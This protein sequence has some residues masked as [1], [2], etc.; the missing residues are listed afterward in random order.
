M[1]FLTRILSNLSLDG[2]KPSVIEVHG[3]SLVPVSRA[4]IL[5]FTLRARRNI[6]AA[7]VKAGDRVALLAPNSAKWA[8]CDLAI[9]SEGAIVVPLYSRQ[10]PHEL[11]VMLNDCKP[12]LLIAADETL[13]Q[14]ILDAW[15]TPCQTICFDPLFAGEASE[16]PTF[17]HAPKDPVTIIYTSGTSGVPKGVILNCAN[18]DYMLPTTYRAIQDITGERG[19]DDKVFHFLPFCFA[20]S[21]MMLWTQLYRPN[22][23]TASTDLTN[24][25]QEM[26]TAD[27]NYYLNVPA[28]L[29]RIKLGVGSKVREQGGMALTLYSKAVAAYRRAKNGESKALDGLWLMLGKKLVFPK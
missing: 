25:V 23:I 4:T 2:E 7:G 9:L 8:A 24:L 17:E 12:T 22:P 14:S 29:E 21:R 16:T 26:G 3:E 6:A 5:E 15:T 10:D 19:I 13:E 20:G 27:P 11:A 1:S 28:V 18:V